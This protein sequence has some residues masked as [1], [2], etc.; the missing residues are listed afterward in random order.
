MHYRK[1][2]SPINFFFCLIFA[3]TFKKQAKDHFQMCAM[4][5]HT[6]VEETGG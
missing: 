1:D 4:C 2:I 5:K 6:P 3:F